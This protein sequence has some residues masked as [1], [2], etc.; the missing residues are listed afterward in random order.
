M[1]NKV[2]IKLGI[3]LIVLGIMFG[4]INHWLL[5]S[6]DFTIKLFLAFP[7]FITW[8]IS[9]I[10]FPGAEM[11][12]LR[13]KEDNRVFWQNSPKLH[14]IMWGIALAIGAVAVVFLMSYYHIE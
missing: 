2:G 12:K 11:D 13:T 3:S 5:T 6:G 8:G 1:K 14:K 9:F 7:I 4:F 10:F